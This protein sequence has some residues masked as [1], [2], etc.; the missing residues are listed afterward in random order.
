LAPGPL[1]AAQVDMPRHLTTFANAANDSALAPVAGTSASASEE[2]LP[3]AELQAL[4]RELADHPDGE[5][6][7]QR[8]VAFLNFSRE[9]ARFDEVR[10]SGSANLDSLRLQAAQLDGA[11]AER[12]RRSEITGA[13]ALQ[14]KSVLLEVLVDDPNSRRAALSDWVKA[15]EP[16]RGSASSSDSFELAKARLI[17]AWRA[18]PAAQRQSAVLEM[19][20]EKLRTQHFA[21]APLLNSAGAPR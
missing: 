3:A 17:A 5:A 20:L 18:Q 16:A 19:Q 6:E 8:I 12:W 15:H 4:R 2:V 10:R 14:L 9:W 13:Q 21:N 11:L 7:V 1:R